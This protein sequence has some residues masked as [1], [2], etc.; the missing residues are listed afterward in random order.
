MDFWCT[1]GGHWWTFA[2][3]PVDLD[4]RPWRLVDFCKKSGAIP[5]DFGGLFKKS[6]DFGFKAVDFRFKAV[7]FDLRPWISI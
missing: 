6:V 4:L 5:V 2:K 3:N 7:D 1:S